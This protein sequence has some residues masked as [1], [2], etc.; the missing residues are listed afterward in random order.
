MIERNDT[1]EKVIDLV[2]SKLGI[3]KAKVVPS[4]TLEDLGADSLEVIEVVMRLEDLFDIQID[5]EDIEKLKTIDD[6]ISYIHTLRL[7]K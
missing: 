5:D 6:L 7:S 4:A 3:D 1:V 2:A